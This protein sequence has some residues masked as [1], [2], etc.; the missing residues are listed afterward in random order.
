M[1]DII[2]CE[3]LTYFL[4]TILY[5]ARICA[6]SDISVT[7]SLVPA[8]KIETNAVFAVHCQITGL[9]EDKHRVEIF[10]IANQRSVP[11]STSQSV[12][13]SVDERVLLAVRQMEDGSVVYFLTI[14]GAT[15]A[16][17]AEYSCKVIGLYPTITEV[18]SDT[19]NMELTYFP[20]HS[21][22][23]CEPSGSDQPFPVVQE[24]DVITL[25]CHSETGNPIVNI[26][27]KK[28]TYTYPK[29]NVRR[30][31][32]NGRIYA[33]VNVRVK[34]SD[35][36]AVFV[37]EITSNAFPLQKQTCHYGP[38]SVIPNQ[39]NNNNPNRVRD[40]TST[41]IAML[42]STLN[43]SED[44][45]DFVDLTNRCQKECKQS[46][47]SVMYWI[48]TTIIASVLAFI[49]LVFAIVLVILKTCRSSEWD[50]PDYHEPQYDGNVITERMYREIDSRRDGGK[51]YMSLVKSY[52]ESNNMPQVPDKI[53]VRTPLGK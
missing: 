2:L 38:L 11:L 3:I 52:P 17:E 13:D 44:T 8:Q 6:T 19:V 33:T 23:V 39:N 28:G 45:A 49:F 14:T 1:E 29:E 50:S 51:M 21:Y 15:Q 16:D 22:P 20:T 7:A 34:A 10:K 26:G 53:Q 41:S 30:E 18:A 32:K 47:S 48:I 40:S 9:E 42:D 43:S 5:S 46:N 12:G 37:C 27:W 24:G 35:N 36:G 31:E 25:S 4:L